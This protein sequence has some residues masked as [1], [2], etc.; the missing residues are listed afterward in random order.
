LQRIVQLLIL[1]LNI[2][3]YESPKSMLSQKANLLIP[4]A[5]LAS[6]LSLPAQES[7]FQITTFS[8]LGGG[9]SSGSQFTVSGGIAA[10]APAVPDDGPISVV[11]GP[12][13][14]WEPPTPPEHPLLS[15]ALTNGTVIVSWPKS[16]TT[17]ILEEITA[18]SDAVGQWSPVAADPQ[19]IDSSI[20][21]TIP[22]PAGNRFYRLN[23]HRSH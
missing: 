23:S 6:G 13:P 20:Q 12:W 17:W 3:H 22:L 11:G 21:V 15:A 1:Y 2:N 7:R 8:D 9:V 10:S 18:L 4:V 19:A 5:L 16:Q 14:I